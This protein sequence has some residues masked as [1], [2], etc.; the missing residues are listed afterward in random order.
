M[1]SYAFHLIHSVI[2]VVMTGLPGFGRQRHFTHT[3]S[4]RKGQWMNQFGVSISYDWTHNLR[5]KGQQH[6]IKNNISNTKFIKKI[7]GDTKGKEFHIPERSRTQSSHMT[8]VY[9]IKLLH[10]SHS[11]WATESALVIETKRWLKPPTPPPTTHIALDLD[12]W[13]ATTVKPNLFKQFFAFQFL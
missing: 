7:I 3:M 5:Q 10:S 11:S 6:I 9:M 4:C 1:A 8:K 12:R 2:R 13:H